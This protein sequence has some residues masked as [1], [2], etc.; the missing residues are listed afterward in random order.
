MVDAK[1]FESEPNFGQR[2]ASDDWEKFLSSDSE[3]VRSWEW[4][5]CLA[6]S[7]SDTIINRG[8]VTVGDIV[9]YLSTEVIL[10][11]H[12]SLGKES[13]EPFT[14]NATQTMYRVN[15]QVAHNLLLTSIYDIVLWHIGRSRRGSASPLWVWD[16]E[17]MS[18]KD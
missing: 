14:G 3:T 13:S 18:T 17:I 11:T 8:N 15:H 5:A 7:R 1:G 9:P 6:R 10:P 4:L 2:R 12:H 16:F